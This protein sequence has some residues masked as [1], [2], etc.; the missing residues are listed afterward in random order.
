MFWSVLA[1]QYLGVELE[2]EEPHEVPAPL[3]EIG[4]SCA[5]RLGPPNSPHWDFPIDQRAHDNANLGKRSML[6]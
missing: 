2:A 4:F 5:D 3:S 1:R 6:W